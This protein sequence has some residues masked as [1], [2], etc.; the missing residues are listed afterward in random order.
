M[1][2]ELSGELLERFV[3]GVE[4]L[5][6]ALEGIAS[7]KAPESPDHRFPLSAY[8]GFDWGVI[9]AEP[10]VRDQSGPMVV[11]WNGFTFVRRFAESQK[12]GKA[13]MFSRNAGRSEDG[14]E[15]FTLVKFSD[16]MNLEALPNNFPQERPRTQRLTPA[17]SATAQAE[18]PATPENEGRHTAPVPRNR[19]LTPD[20]QTHYRNEAQ[21]ATDDFMFVT[22][23]QRL[24]PKCTVKGLET[25]RGRVCAEPV[26][27]GNA[28]RQ[29][30]AMV[31]YIE[32]RAELERAGDTRAAHN[33]AA[34]EA[35]AHYKQG[36]NK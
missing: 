18:A 33:T 4:R 12:Y 8:A 29:Y 17:P 5:A 2:E 34:I 21:T 19:P 35:A 26:N 31:K 20:E 15:Y 9:G 1:N 28:P 30:E 16:N 36:E 10:V 23:V 7:A 13:I 3:C 14:N 32:R 24:Y 25:I 27:A 6:A 22:A 11:R